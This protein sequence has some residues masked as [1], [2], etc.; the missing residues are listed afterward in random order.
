MKPSLEPCRRVLTWL[1]LVV[2]LFVGPAV[3]APA[4]SAQPAPTPA[5]PPAVGDPSAAPPAAPSTTA[6][7]VVDRI[8]QP[9]ITT[10]PAPT[11]PAQPATPPELTPP[12][13]GSAAANAGADAK[14]WWEVEAEKP[15]VYDGTYWL[16]PAASKTADGPDAMFVWVLG[17]S[18][19]F[20]I[21]IT[22]AIVYL[23]LKYRHRPG[24][25]PEPSPAHND[26]LEIT[27]TV[28][29]TII[30]VFLFVY[31][32]RSYIDLTTVPETRPENQIMVT[33]Q[34][35]NWSFRYYN[36]VEDNILHVPIDQPVKL[37]MTS[38]DVLH[39]L[40][41]PVFRQKMDVIP[42]RFTYL[43]FWPTK[44]GVYRVYCTEYCGKD[45]SMMK[46]KVVVH[47]ES[48]Y[49]QYLA[50]A[51][52][53]Q[54]SLSGAQLGESVYKK[55]GCEG[56]HTLDGSTKVGPSFKGVY[57][58]DVKVGGA[59]VK[60]DDEYIRNSILAPQAQSRAGFPPSMPV[61]P[62]SDKEIEGVI[63]FIKA[64]K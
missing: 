60:M 55:K 8:P 42:R 47:P 56:C 6:P 7:P 45:H 25:K 10:D 31:G 46:T 32:W 29:P 52:D 33:G 13:A 11:E 50:E 14:P 34:K 49:E 51:R 16:P 12:T 58:T 36:G 62:L 1:L 41:V 57:G 18:A 35:W 54:M 4:A 5:T 22:G 64:Q 27:W 26:A 63:E 28:I 17:L 21:A 38:T 19:F 30:C 44:P 24:H 53:K 23:V 9:P 2:G 15:Y 20:F 48:K 61:I 59:T 37:T 3:V 39:S 43:Y 40:F